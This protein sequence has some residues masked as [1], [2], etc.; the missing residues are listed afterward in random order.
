M[1]STM[2]EK[3]LAAKSGKESVKPGEYINVK[4]DYVVGNEGSARMAIDD[5]RRLGCDRIF[6]K[7]RLLIIADHSI[8]NKTIDS[9]EVV[10]VCRD[11]CREYDLPFYEPG[12]AGI[13]HVMVP[14]NGWVGA[15]DVVIGSDSHICTYGALGCFATGSG[16]TDLL[17]SMVFGD[18]WMRVP[19]NIKVTYTGKLQPYVSGK[20]LILALIGKIGVDGARY[21]AIEF[22]G[23]TLGELSMDSR[24]TLCNMTIEAGAK[25]GIMTPDEKTIEYMKR[26]VRPYKI[27]KS[28][29]DA[30]FQKEVEIDVSEMEPQVAVPHL[31][32]NLK[33]VSEVE[34]E[35]VQLDQVF[36]GSCTN[37]YLDDIKVA[38]EI[39][40]GRRVHDKTRM[41]VLPG[42][43]DVYIAA[44]KAGY[45]E[46]LAEAGVA[47]GT[48]NCGACGGGH[49]GVL[50]KGEVCASTSNR[51]FQGRMG[52]SESSVY[53]V[54]PAVAAA[55]AV[56][57]YI[58][59]PASL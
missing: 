9:A 14:E 27:Y 16:S 33:P 50:A 30:V 58:I 37:S 1:A 44:L 5:F 38:A 19:E 53:L 3:I 56:A 41:I 26:C 45:I 52:S 8:P 36:I 17:H 24:F 49:H 59:S 43:Q 15:G 54:N 48:P 10:K 34:K 18:I 28:D 2:A 21:Q 13:S 57:G 25:C 35:K 12:K 47:V 20:D 31:P 32:S 6:D 4:L 46:I 11:F 7:E 42:S 55:S 39:L 29:P 23:D 40:K 51:N 22:A